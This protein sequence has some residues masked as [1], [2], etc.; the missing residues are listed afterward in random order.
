MGFIVNY[1]Y[2]NRPFPAR[3]LLDRNPPRDPNA[4]RLAS[5]LCKALGASGLAHGAYGGNLA[6]PMPTD[7]TN[8]DI[9]RQ[10]DI[11]WAY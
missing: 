3:Q 8:L 1:L 4:T 5:M 7:N 2:A 9:K 6:K 10:N 11:R